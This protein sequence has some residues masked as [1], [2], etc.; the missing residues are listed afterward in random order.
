MT[1]RVVRDLLWLL[2]LN[3]ALWL[4]H[5]YGRV[6]PDVALAAVGL[7]LATLLGF[8]LFWRRRVRRRAFLTAYVSPASPLARWLRGGWL[9]AASQSVAAALLTLILMMA[10]IRLRDPGVW[11]VLLAAGLALVL[12]QS[13]LRHGLR[14]HASPLYLPAL[15][16]RLSVVLIAVLMLATLTAMALQ[17]AYPAFAGVSLERAVWHLA[18]QEQARSA[19]AQMLLQMAAA[20]DGLRLWLAQQLMPVPGMSLLQL[21]GWLLVLVDE[22]LFVWS[23]LILCQSLLIAVN[24]DDRSA[25]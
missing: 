21:F 23:Y 11:I 17:Q 15:S 9:L 1:D 2:A 13:L 10:L 8:G 16:W 12:V 5:R 6:L 20:K 3:T 24:S 4:L 7:P 18:D 14:N 25:S 19:T 22:A